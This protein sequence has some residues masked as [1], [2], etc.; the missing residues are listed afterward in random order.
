ML[1]TYLE[2]INV[3]QIKIFKKDMKYLSIELVNK[4]ARIEAQM[5]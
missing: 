1:R 2:L 4:V 5:I 3:L